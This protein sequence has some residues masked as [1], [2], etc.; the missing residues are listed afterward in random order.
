V[1]VI[2]TDSHDTTEL[3]NVTWGVH[4]ARRGW[5][6]RDKIANTWD[7]ERFLEWAAAKRSS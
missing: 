6:D 2:S 3:V 4:Q 1:F 5:V 7:R